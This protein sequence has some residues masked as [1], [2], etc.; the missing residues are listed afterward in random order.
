LI[1]NGRNKC[2]HGG[3]AIRKISFSVV[4]AGFMPAIHVFFVFSGLANRYQN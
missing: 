1:A 2:G 3:V 4:M